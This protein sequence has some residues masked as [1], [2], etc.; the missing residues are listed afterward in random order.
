MFVY[1]CPMYSEI[2]VNQAP[3][4][5]AML[6]TEMRYLAASQKWIR[7]YGLQGKEII[8]KSHYEIFPEIGEDWKQIHRECL[9]GAI[10]QNEDA[11]FLREDGSEQWL[12]WDVRPWYKEDGKVG[13]LLMYTDDITARKKTEQQLLL[14]ETQF[15]GSFEAS[16]NG[17]AIVSLQGNWVNVNP[18]M[19]HI[20]GYSKEELMQLTFQDITH[21]DDLAP[22]MALVHELL[23]G[24]REYYHLEKR[25]KHKDGHYIWALLSVSL[26]KDSAGKPKHFVSQVTDIDKQRLTQHKLEQTLNKLEGLMEASTQVGIIGTDTKGLITTY[27]KG[28]ENLLGYT[29]DEMLYKQTPQIIHV[30]EEVEERAKELK[31]I[32]GREVSGFDV[33]VTLPREQQ[34]ETREWTFLRKDGTRFSVQLTITAVHENG[35]LVGY[36]GIFADISEIK[37][38]ESEIKSLLDVTRDQNERLK[39]FAHIVSHNLRSHSG[40]ITILTEL[41]LEEHPELESDEVVQNLKLSAA[42]LKETIAHLNEVVAMNT[43]VTQNLKKLHLKTRIDTAIQNVK[44]IAEANNVVIENYVDDSYYVLGIEAY[45]DSIIIN[46]LTNGIKYRSLQRQPVVKINAAADSG[47]VTISFEDN[48]IGMDLKLVKHKLFGMYKTF[49]GNA[50]ARGIGLFITKNQVEALGGKIDVESTE[51]VGTTFKVYLK[52]EN[53]H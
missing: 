35:E 46:F 32:L 44:A 12:M 24:K 6:D 10:N 49:H 40:N 31:A 39:N 29:P 23:E 21:P 28:A 27:N 42:N 11:Y 25:Y 16:P 1:C 45:L 50:D 22:D 15:R 3:N 2:F 19:C 43:T 41:L 47:Y 17:I 20:L 52:N 34:Y 38:V 13:G 7:D 30:K 37:R 36:L 26:V 5:I 8:G 18:A 48:G 9:A 4:A 14:S 51:N 33:F 53:T